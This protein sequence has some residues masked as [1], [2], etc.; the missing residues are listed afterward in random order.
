MK[1]LVFC[2]SAMLFAVCFSLCSFN[3][4]AND[5][6]DVYVTCDG[7]SCHTS[8]G[9][10]TIW[11]NN[12]GK[13][14]STVAS[15]YDF[16]QDPTA[17][18]RDFIGWYIY[19]KDTGAQLDPNLL[20][21][22]QVT[23]Y[24]IPNHGLKIVAQWTP[25][26]GYPV[27]TFTEAVMHN[28]KCEP[29]SDVKVSLIFGDT[30]YS[31]YGYVTIPES[32][33][34]NWSGPYLTR[35][36]PM[37]GAYVMYD[38]KWVNEVCEWECT[39]SDIKR[40]GS[41]YTT[42]NYTGKGRD[43][44]FGRRPVN[45]FFYAAS[46]VAANVSSISETSA[47]D[48]IADTTIVPATYTMET[49]VFQSG[50]SF[51]AAVSAAQSTYATSNV[52]VVDINLKDDQGAKV[53]QLSDYVEVKVDIPDTYVIQEGNT[54]VVY[55]LNDSGVLEECETVYHNEDPNNR[56]VTFKTNHF[57]VYVLVE[58]SPEPVVVPTP[59]ESKKDD[60]DSSSVETGNTEDG[61]VTEGTEGTVTTD[62]DVVVD[63]TV[64]TGKSDVTTGSDNV[65]TEDGTTEGVTINETTEANTILD[66]PLFLIGIAIGL[67]AV[68][69]VVVLLKKNSNK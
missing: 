22:A 48:M 1:K 35:L 16:D 59:E 53:T 31:G 43:N 39:V 69:V 50:E 60:T 8:D 66:N 2:L 64:D 38:G 21:T 11:G 25:R 3:S 24:I 7:G 23:S 20:T 12:I 41:S 55:Y 65:V 36:E 34:N 28:D 19:N 68:A 4:Y 17:I 26:A 62:E 40:H 49:E 61:E 10:D 5:T 56:Y 42:A 30:C 44:S 63:A 67:V 13:V 54:V 32:V 18:D 45:D 58:K 6:V 37:N 52:V 14:G 47:S 15:V 57:S 27:T 46:F 9:Y 51:D 33:Y 29:C